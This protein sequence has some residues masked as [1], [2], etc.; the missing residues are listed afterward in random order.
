MCKL[1]GKWESLEIKECRYYG[2]MS[3]LCHHPD[4]NNIPCH[5]DGKPQKQEVVNGSG[6]RKMLDM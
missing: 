3:K 1:Y 6:T 2:D 4:N 5:T